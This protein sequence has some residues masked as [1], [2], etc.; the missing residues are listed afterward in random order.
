MFTDDKVLWPD[1]VEPV[2]LRNLSY[3]RT[4]LPF[5]FVAALLEENGVHYAD[6]HVDNLIKFK[7]SFLNWD[8]AFKQATYS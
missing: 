1:L 3:L 2:V 6:L 5:G 8:P 4:N 7:V